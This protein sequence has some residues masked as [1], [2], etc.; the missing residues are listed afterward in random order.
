VRDRINL[1]N[2][3][4]LSAAGKR[5]LYVDP[6]CKESVKCYEQLT[7]KEGTNEPDKKMGLDHVPDATG[8]YLFTRFAHTPA[9]AKHV[10]HMNR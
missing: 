3:R 10:P 6:S 8:Y 7:Y 1:V 9:H 5:A 2:G 4:F